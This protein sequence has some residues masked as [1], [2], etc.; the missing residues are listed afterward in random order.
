VKLAGRLLF[1]AVFLGLIIGAGADVGSVF[2]G[3]WSNPNRGAPENIFAF[4]EFKD[5]FESQSTLWEAHFEDGSYFYGYFFNYKF[6][7][8][9]KWGVTAVVINPDGK[10]YIERVELPSKDLRF[11]RDSID[12]RFG[13]FWQ[14]GEYPA[15][16]FHVDTPGFLADLTYKNLVP[17]FIPGDG[18]T[19]YDAG[20]KTFLKN[21]AFCPWGEVAGIIGVGGKRRQVKGQ[22]YADHDHANQIFTK[23]I[24]EMHT[25][26]GWPADPDNGYSISFVEYIGGPQYS[27]LRAR[28]LILMKKGSIVMATRDFTVTRSNFVK[29]D[30]TGFEYPQR[31]QLEAR[32]PGGTL[33]GGWK[34][35]KLIDVLD[36]FNEL[37]APLQPIARS[38]F[39][40]PVF[41]RMT[42]TFEGLFNS[43]EDQIPI[44]VEGLCK[45][46]Y[47]K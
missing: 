42:G 25:Y 41:Y 45:A 2:E 15:Y 28:W 33:V 46:V 11:S 18:Y 24:K 6:A 21:V 44:K 31:W 38:F 8:Y 26:R 22:G 14:N 16:R 5:T 27:G 32:A 23:Q 43:G 17:P 9:K 47:T 3:D 10:R 34:K 29:D 30:S 1:S 19:W 13:S 4:S 37:P 12:L 20:K 7:S 35:S 39:T 40:R 36:V